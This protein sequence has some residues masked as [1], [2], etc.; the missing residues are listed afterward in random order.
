MQARMRWPKWRYW[1][2]VMACI[3]KSWMSISAF[4]DCWRDCSAPKPTWT[5]NVPRE[6]LLRPLRRRWILPTRTAG[7]VAIHRRWR[8]NPRFELPSTRPRQ[9]RELRITGTATVFQ[10][11]KGAAAMMAQAMRPPDLSLITLHMQPRQSSDISEH[12]QGA[13]FNL[14]GKRL[15]SNAWELLRSVLDFRLQRI[16][17]AI[18]GK[19]FDTKYKCSIM[20]YILTETGSITSQA[21][22]GLYCYEASTSA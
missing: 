19:A 5:A 9:E 12:S 10:T 20:N 21:W 7:R 16:V 2:K 17:V 15:Q 1:D 6:P 3:G 18:L 8:C 22:D 4:P 13:L 11:G 14:V